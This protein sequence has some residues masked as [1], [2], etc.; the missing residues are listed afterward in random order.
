LKAPPQPYND[1]ECGG[2]T[3]LFNAAPTADRLPTFQQCCS[4]EKAGCWA[5]VAWVGKRCQASALQNARRTRMECGGS[6]PLFKVAPT[7]DRLPTFQ[8]RCSGEKVGC[9]PGVAWAGNRCQAS[10]LQGVA[11]D[12]DPSGIRAVQ[13][14]TT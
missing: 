7:A 4:G 1:L 9:C 12:R 11:N 8:Q 10:A 6:T 3:P 14:Y 2:S 13:L 5:G